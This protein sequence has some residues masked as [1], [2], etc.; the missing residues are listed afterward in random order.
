MELEK[1]EVSDRLQ[2]TRNKMSA[3][4]TQL[5]TFR[6]ERNDLEVQVEVSESKIRILQEE[7]RKESSKTEGIK[8]QFV[9][10]L[11]ESRRECEDVRT[12]LVR[13]QVR[14]FFSCH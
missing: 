11:D 8:A 2:I 6:A 12:E 5:D 13:S 14:F 10:S 7:K 4:Q 1:R 9:E 3:L